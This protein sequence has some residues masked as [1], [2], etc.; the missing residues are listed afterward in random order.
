MVFQFE[1]KFLSRRFEHADGQ[2]LAFVRVEVGE[3]GI[4]EDYVVRIRFGHLSFGEC[5]WV[6]F[7]RLARGGRPRIRTPGLF[8]VNEAL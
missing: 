2:Q 7:K 3:L 4:E 8:G 5:L 1:I 6:S